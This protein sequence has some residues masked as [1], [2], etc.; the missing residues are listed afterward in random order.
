[1]S[2]AIQCVGRDTEELMIDQPGSISFPT[3]TLKCIFLLPFILQN[4]FVVDIGPYLFPYPLLIIWLG[5]KV[6]PVEVDSFVVRKAH[7]VFF[8]N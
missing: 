7:V 6:A 3:M 5:F 8:V 1:M 4:L 2:D